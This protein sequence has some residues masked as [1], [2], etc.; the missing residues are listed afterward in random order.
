MNTLRRFFSTV[1]D[2]AS[3]PAGYKKHLSEPLSR[4]LGYLY[5]LLVCLTFVGIVVTVGTYVIVRPAMREFIATSVQELPHAYPEELI[6]TVTGGTLRANVDQPYVLDPWFWKGP[7][8]Q[9]EIADG[10][11]PAHFLT[12]DEEGSA[13]EYRV[14]DTLILATRSSIV[15][16]DNDGSL[17]VMLLK[18]MEENFT[19]DKAAYD[20]L[21][22]AVLPFIN[23]LP[24]I[25][26]V[27]VLLLLLLAPFVGA[28]FLW[29]LYLLYLLFLTLPVWAI[30]AM[31][32]RG[33]SYDQIWKISIF[34]LTLPLLVNFVLGFLPSMGFPFLFSIIFLVW[35]IIV[36][37]KLPHTGHRPIAPLQPQK[38]TLIAKRGS[39]KMEKK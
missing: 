21:V 14:Y 38:R 35:M 3:K 31:M 34:G 22:A 23:M 37:S 6:V 33:L 9:D 11:V 5:W 17:Q 18:D 13:E 32:G 39:K 7:T 36:L 30:S 19:I 10:D 27:C 28:G 12:I 25:I 8:I 1:L 16:P 29:I 20:A 15:F 26:D 2:S 4:P 24:F